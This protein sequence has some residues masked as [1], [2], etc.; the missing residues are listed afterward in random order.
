MATPWRGSAVGSAWRSV[1]SPRVIEL[2]GRNPVA[3]AARGIGGE[4]EG[5]VCAEGRNGDL[6]SETQTFAQRAA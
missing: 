2:F 4:A 5:A 6:V 3:P 1:A